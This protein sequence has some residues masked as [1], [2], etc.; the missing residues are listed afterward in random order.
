MRLL[1][2]IAV[3]AASSAR[4][5]EVRVGVAATLATDLPDPVSGEYARFGPGPGVQVPVWVELA[6]WALLRA[7]VRGDLGV[8]SDRVSWKREIDGEPVRFYDDEQFAMFVAGGLTLG[9]EVVFPMNGAVTPYL[10][11]EAGGAWVGTYHSFGGPTA[12]L[13]ALDQND[14]QD[15]GNVD[16]YTSQLT[17]LTEVH[18]GL[19]LG[20]D[21]RYW[22]ELGYSAAWLGASDLRK[23][24][25][26]L[27]ARRAPWGW[28]A[29]RLGVGVRFGR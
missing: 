17:V 24:P 29:I 1:L 13:I 10:G 26:A 16:P 18:I 25:P 7:T 3:L 21:D 23:S 22:A 5:E 12:L 11:A 19:G 14:L 20:T 4:A 9:P 6:P 28:N 2:S 8:G 15:A 27:A